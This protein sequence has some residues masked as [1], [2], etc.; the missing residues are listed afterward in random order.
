MALGLGEGGGFGGEL[1]GLETAGGV[2]GNFELADEEVEA[3]EFG[4]GGRREL[5]FDAGG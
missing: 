1:A 3:G 4:G 5:C 2:E